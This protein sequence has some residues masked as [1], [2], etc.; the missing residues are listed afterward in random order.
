MDI[1]LGLLLEI[2]TGRGISVE[3][4]KSN[5]AVPST[6]IGAA[7]KVLSD[8]DSNFEWVEHQP[9]ADV[10][11][12][13]RLREMMTCIDK[14]HAFVQDDCTY[15]LGIID[16]GMKYNH[17]EQ[18]VK[19]LSLLGFF[20][21]EVVAGQAHMGKAMAMTSLNDQGVI[22]CA[23]YIGADLAIVNTF[24][25]LDRDTNGSFYYDYSNLENSKRRLSQILEGHMTSLLLESSGLH[26]I[27]YDG[28]ELFV[29]V[30]RTYATRVEGIPS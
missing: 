11:P 17:T 16:T 12:R 8:V 14:T 1:H 15:R 3:R 30:Q 13:D 27:V 4:L 26:Q 9:K 24:Y 20:G 6:Y 29:N 5:S 21:L 7:N 22:T 23:Q 25:P 19:A 10:S 2:L 18:T 28:F